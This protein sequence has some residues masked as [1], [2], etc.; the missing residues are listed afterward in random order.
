[1]SSDLEHRIIQYLT[2]SMSSEDRALFLQDMHANVQLRRA[3][4]VYKSIWEATNSLNY[5]SENIDYTWKS[6]ESKITIKPRYYLTKSSYVNLAAS[7]IIAIVTIVSWNFISKKS[8]YKTSQYAENYILEDN[9]QVILNPNSKLILSNNFNSSNREV[10]LSGEA[11]FDVFESNKKFVVHTT[12][13]DIVVHGTQFKVSV[14]EDNQSVLVELFDGHLSYIQNNQE[15]YLKSGDL[16]TSSLDEISRTTSKI[17]MTNGGYVICK[18][19]TL[20]DILAQIKLIYDVNHHIK[21][22]LLKDV[23]SVS[24]PKNDL[25][26]C[27]KILNKISGNNFALINNSIVLK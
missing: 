25:K 26:N 20:A 27:I 17:S 19:S 7:I 10:T 16:L 3:F 8:H 9:S 4:D 11:F 18:N 23:Y 22:R 12:I 15:Y 6:F 2:N 21:P 13:G 14:N 24:L 1:M 5:E